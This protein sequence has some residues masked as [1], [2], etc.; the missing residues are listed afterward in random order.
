VNTPS[1]H[2][3]HSN[4]HT[5]THP[6]RHTSPTNTPQ[7]K[8]TQPTQQHTNSPTSTHTAISQR[9]CH[10]YPTPHNTLFIPPPSVPKTPSAHATCPPSCAWDAPTPQ[11]QKTPACPSATDDT[12]PAP[13]P[14]TAPHAHAPSAPLVASPCARAISAGA[15]TLGRST[16]ADAPDPKW[17][18]RAG[19]TRASLCACAHNKPCSAS[20]TAPTLR[21]RPARRPR[22]A[23]AA[24][25]ALPC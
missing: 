24:P 23:T 25:N 10:T 8:R 12:N 20:P 5:K 18:Q 16:R 13:A 22:T 19:R 7:P 2:E 1:R 14:T 6:K 11:A 3:N 15:S 9:L 17:L 4:A 21:C